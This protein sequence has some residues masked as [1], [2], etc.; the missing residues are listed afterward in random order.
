MPV[1]ANN[2]PPPTDATRKSL[3]M[4]AVVLD[5]AAGEGEAANAATIFARCARAGGVTLDV[6]VLAAAAMLPAPRS[7]RPTPSPTPSADDPGEVRMTNGKYAGKRLADIYRGD[8][9]YVAW[10]A[11][12]YSDVN[13]Q[14]AAAAVLAAADRGAS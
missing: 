12:A 4:L 13:V 3:K 2:P 6:L 1:Y 8:P 7:P 11:R 5:P 10:L 9:G 14:R